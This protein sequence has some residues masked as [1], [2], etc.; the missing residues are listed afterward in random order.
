MSP[1]TR[2]ENLLREEI[3]FWASYIH[4]CEKQQHLSVPPR[5]FEAL[6]LAEQKLSWYL[7]SSTSNMN[8]K[9]QLH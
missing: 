7:I 6:H 4:R 1:D 2:L 5:A 9:V 3:N 8:L